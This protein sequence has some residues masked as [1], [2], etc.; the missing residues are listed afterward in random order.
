MPD[1]TVF[2]E[3]VP[4]PPFDELVRELDA[5][6]DDDFIAEVESALEDLFLARVGLDRAA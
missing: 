5:L 2:E 1:L 3:T 4:V 6:I